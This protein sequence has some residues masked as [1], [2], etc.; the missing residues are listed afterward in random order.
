MEMRIA[1]VWLDER[2][3]TG[4]NRNPPLHTAVKRR[5]V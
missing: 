3:P 5:M 2:K 4:E 1:A